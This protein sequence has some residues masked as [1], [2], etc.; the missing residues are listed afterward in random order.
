MKCTG[1]GHEHDEKVGFGSVCDRCL[2]WLHVCVNCALHDRDSRRCRSHTTDYSGD[3][4]DRNFCEEFMPWNGR[5]A[6]G[7]GESAG[8][9]FEGL[10][11]DGDRVDP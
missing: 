5:H 10:F 7:T 9:R 8:A 1:C 11:R 4:G 2:A 6:P 3:P